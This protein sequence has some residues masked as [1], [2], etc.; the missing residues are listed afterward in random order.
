MEEKD[1][2]AMY[3]L[4]LSIMFLIVFTSTL[5][6]SSDAYAANNSTL[7]IVNVTN[8]EPNLY[9]V[10]ITPATI[11][12]TPGNTT[13]VICNG[14]VYDINGYADVNGSKSNATLFDK[15]QGYA[16]TLDDNYRYQN[17][18][19]NCTQ[20]GASTTNASCIC[21]FSVEYFANNGTWDCN[22]TIADNFGISDTLNSSFA[23]V[24]TVVGINTPTLIDY[25]NLSVTQTS[26]NMP[27]NISNFGNV[28][29]NVSVRGYGGTSDPGNPLNTSMNCVTGNITVSNERY[30][31][32]N[33]TFVDLTN[34]TTQ[35]LNWTLPVRTNDTNYGN[36]TNTSYWQLEIPLSVSGYCNGTLEF[37]AIQTP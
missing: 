20:L 10:V 8:T 22:M 2:L 13:L 12:L 15:T 30:S 25:G 18:S 37:S 35:I 1:N 4:V 26:D 9:N 14:S 16:G 29:I 27:A 7:T 28:P 34:T 19:C 3:F 33:I 31:N 17:T 5:F 36:D 32:N 21:S 11:D 6:M 24:N 23:T